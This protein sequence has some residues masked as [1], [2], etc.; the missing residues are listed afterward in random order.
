MPHSFRKP[1]IEVGEVDK[2]CSR[3][4]FRLDALRDLSKHAVESTEISD[5][6]EWAHHRSLADIAFQLNS[7]LTHALPAEPIDQ[8][9]GEFFEETS[10][11]FGAVHVARSFSGDHQKPRRAHGIRLFNSRN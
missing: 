1:K 2:D 3:G 9:T 11:H 8:A 10:R 5:D 7:S 6:F 4:R